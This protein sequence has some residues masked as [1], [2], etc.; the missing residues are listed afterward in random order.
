MLAILFWKFQLQNGSN[1]LALYLKIGWCPFPSTT[2]CHLELLM[3]RCNNTCSRQKYLINSE[4]FHWWNA[5]F[6][7][8]IINW[9]QWEIGRVDLPRCCWIY[10]LL[11]SGKPSVGPVAGR[12]MP[13][14][15]KKELIRHVKIIPKDM[16]FVQSYHWRAET[17]ITIATR[18]NSSF[19]IDTT[20]PL[21]SSV[22]FGEL[23]LSPMLSLYKLQ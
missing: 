16:E 18:I 19:Y 2:R 1:Y 10:V 15:K 4:V 3:Y 14:E 21:P 23:S 20:R 5:E 11:N 12:M 17:S 6:T 13:A 7:I 8:Y 22:G 9:I